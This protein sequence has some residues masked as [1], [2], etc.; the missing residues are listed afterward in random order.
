MQAWGESYIYLIFANGI[1]VFFKYK[2]SCPECI[3]TE[4]A[5]RKFHEMRFSLRCCE[6]LQD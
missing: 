2:K 3:G 1:R 4:A 6:M 5:L